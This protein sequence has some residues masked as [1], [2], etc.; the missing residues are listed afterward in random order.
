M[1]DLLLERIAATR[2]AINET[3]AL[4]DGSHQDSKFAIQTRA[5]LQE[6]MNVEKQ[7]LLTPGVE[8]TDD[9]GH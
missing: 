7:L 9:A 2:A 5:H 3:A 6:L 8:R 4:L 1:A